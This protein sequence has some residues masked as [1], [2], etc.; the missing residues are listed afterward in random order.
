MENGKLSMVGLCIASAAVTA[1]APAA[2]EPWDRA[3]L[4]LAVVCLAGFHAVIALVMRAVS[5]SRPGP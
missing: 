1:A 2:A 5:V 4:G 3:W